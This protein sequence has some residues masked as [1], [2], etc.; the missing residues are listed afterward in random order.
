MVMY[1]EWHIDHVVP[2]SLFVYETPSDDEF[3]ACWSL[4]NL[5]PMWGEANLEKSD[6]LPDGRRVADLSEDERR[7]YVVKARVDA[8]V[9]R[10]IHEDGRLR[11]SWHRARTPSSRIQGTLETEPPSNPGRFNPRDRT[12]FVRSRR[13][14]PRGDAPYAKP[15]AAVQLTTL[16]QQTAQRVYHASARRHRYPGGRHTRRRARIGTIRC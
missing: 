10:E 5:R 4:A 11:R 16:C 3:L 15:H 2:K 13:F 6:L 9:A 12:P 14:E 8:A 7:A 1:G